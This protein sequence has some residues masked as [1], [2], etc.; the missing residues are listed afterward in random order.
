MEKWI[1]NELDKL[2]NIKD[3]KKFFGTSKYKSYL[4]INNKKVEHI[5]KYFLADKW[6]V[7]N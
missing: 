3:R 2:E 1:Y 4:I 7:E 6:E 5:F